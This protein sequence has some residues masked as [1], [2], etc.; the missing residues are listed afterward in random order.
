MTTD[1]M[2]VSAF[3]KLLVFLLATSCVE[4]FRMKASVLV[5]AQFIY[6]LPGAMSSDSKGTLLSALFTEPSQLSAERTTRGVDPTADHRLR[7]G[8]EHHHAKGHMVTPSNGSKKISYPIAERNHFNEDVKFTIPSHDLAS[9]SPSYIDNGTAGFKGD[10]DTARKSDL[11]PVSPT[12]E[13]TTDKLIPYSR[14]S[15]LNYMNINTGTEAKGYHHMFSFLANDADNSSY[16]RAY[17]ANKESYC[18]KHGLLWSFHR[19][20]FAPHRHFQEALAL[21]IPIASQLLLSAHN[22]QITYMDYD[23]MIV[24]HNVDINQIFNDVDKTHEFPCTVYV[25]ADPYVLNSGFWSL[26]NTNWV[27]EHFLQKWESFRFKWDVSGVAGKRVTGAMEPDQKGFVAAILHYA[28]KERGFD[29]DICAA[30]KFSIRSK[31]W[32]NVSKEVA[33]WIK[34]LPKN[35]PKYK[36]W[37]LKA[38]RRWGPKKDH[39]SYQS[40]FDRDGGGGNLFYLCF[41]W[42]MQHILKLPISD[43]S[44][45]VGKEDGVCFMGYQ[46]KQINRHHM[47]PRETFKKLRNFSFSEATNSRHAS[48]MY[49]TGYSTDLFALHAHLEAND[50]NFCT[51]TVAAND[52]ITDLTKEPSQLSWPFR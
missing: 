27:R 40:V 8:F 37:Q 13:T 1:C 11:L 14:Q 30:E 34:T 35:Y 47:F 17:V 48:T 31:E 19:S 24:D 51:R 18:K 7:Y 20:F 15:R 10:I 45:P 49:G 26:M 5:T 4:G 46:G 2:S 23:M 38:N 43:L 44:F 22:A 3:M 28:L 42:A 52:F 29:P 12:F 41:N 32:K 50:Q 9:A 25:Q 39:S 6:T 36:L 16:C 33:N 21:R